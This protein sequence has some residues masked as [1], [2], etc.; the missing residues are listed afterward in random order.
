[1]IGKQSEFNQKSAWWAFNFVNNWSTLRFNVINKEVRD[2]IAVFQKKAFE[3]RKKMEEQ[4]HQMN[5]SKE[6][7]TFL[8]KQ[9]ND[10]AS[11]IVEQWWQ[12]AWKLVGKYSDGYVTTGENPI[13]MK[14]LGYPQWWLQVSDFAAW[15]G[16]SFAPKDSIRH[17]LVNYHPQNKTTIATIATKSVTS[18]APLTCPPPQVVYV[19]KVSLFHNLVYTVF[20]VLLGSGFF[21]CMQW[22]KRFGYQ[23]LQ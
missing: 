3:I 8:Q 21:M 6:I 23:P 20:G 22:R 18:T 9:S 16:D 4:A 12:L 5:S 13:E 14:T 15:P 1:L 17:E 19:H 2:V 10:F 11:S 7:N